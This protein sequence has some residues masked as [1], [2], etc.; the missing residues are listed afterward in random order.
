MSSKTAE[1]HAHFCFFLALPSKTAFFTWVVPFKTVNLQSGSLS[2]FPSASPLC[3]VEFHA[4]SYVSLGFDLLPCKTHGN[5]HAFIFCSAFVHVA[6]PA[7][8]VIQTHF[9]FPSFLLSITVASIVHHSNFICLWPCSKPSFSLFL[10]QS[11]AFKTIP[12]Q[13]KTIFFSSS[14]LIVFVETT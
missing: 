1:F 2:S 7:L 13:P 12:L 14:A 8:A 4:S 6:R 11:L 10:S 3:F 5:L 9:F